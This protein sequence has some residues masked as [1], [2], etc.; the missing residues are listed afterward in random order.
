MPIHSAYNNICKLNLLMTLFLIAIAAS[1]IVQIDA[2]RIT[3][4]KKS[5]SQWAVHHRLKV[6]VAQPK[7]VKGT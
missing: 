5:T 6:K 4:Q 3:S 7:Y 2:H 1:I